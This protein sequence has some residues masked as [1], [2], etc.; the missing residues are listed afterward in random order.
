MHIIDLARL[1]RNYAFVNINYYN[2]KNSRN[3]IENV[4]EDMTKV[5]NIKHSKYDVYCGR[6]GKGQDG[7]FGSPF[8]VDIDGT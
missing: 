4:V 2:K 1:K 3:H 6:A 7:Y 5:V 8:H